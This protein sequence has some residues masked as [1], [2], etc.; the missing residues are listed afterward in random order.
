MHVHQTFN[1]T[2]KEEKDLPENAKELEDRFLGLMLMTCENLILKLHNERINAF[3]NN[4]PF[5]QL[6]ES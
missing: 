2:R 3:K 1:F 6:K 5:D 4:K